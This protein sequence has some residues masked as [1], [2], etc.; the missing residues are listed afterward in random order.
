M[1]H[2]DSVVL[3]AGL[4]TR[5]KSDLPKTLHELGGRALVV[6]SIEA[7]RSATDRS[8]IVVVGPDIDRYRSVIGEEAELVIQEERLGT[9]H[10]A[11]QAETALKGK[12]DLVLVVHA[13]MPLL[14]SETLKALIAK[15]EEHGGVLSLLAMHSE[16]SRGF[17]RILRDA[18]GEVGGII[19]E[20]HATPEQLAISELNMGAYCYRADWLW[21][22][23]SKIE[24]SPKG[25]YYLTDLVALA[26]SQSSTVGCVHVTD[27]SEVI[28]INTRAHLAEAET[29]L[30]RRINQH[31]LE[32]GVTFLDPATTYISHEATIGPGTVILPNTHLWGLTEI[33]ESC[34]VGPNSIVR[35]AKIGDRCHVESSVLEEATLENDVHVGPFAHLRRGAHLCDGVHV[36]NYAEVKNSQLGPGAKMGHFSYMGDATVGRDANIGAGTITCNYD[37]EKKHHTEIGEGAFIGSDTMLVAPVRIGKGARTGAGSVV[38]RDIPDYSVAVGAPARVIRKLK[39]KDE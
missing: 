31:W 14:R 10:A 21:E 22:N 16:S 18:A 29:A 24:K 27:E 2:C 23:L 19:E 35:D 39:A 9:G 15:Q 11:M 30:R 38:T 34:R 37:G 32:Q 25:E 12:S 4:G 28:G 6:W 7:C 26:V 13:D 36:G 20:A 5:M 1:M 8:P 3:A 33:G 17:G